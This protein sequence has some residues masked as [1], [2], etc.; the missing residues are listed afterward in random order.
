M[1]KPQVNEKEYA[2]LV[3]K[4]MKEHELYEEGMGVE[5]VPDNTEKPSG[6]NIV[7]GAKASGVVTWAES[8]VKNEYQLIV[9]R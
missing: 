5:L 2:Q 3:N 6:L 4:K 1:S 9:T 7:G 8:H